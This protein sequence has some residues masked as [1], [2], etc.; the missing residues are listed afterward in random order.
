MESDTGDS[1]DSTNSG[2]SDIHELHSQLQDS[3]SHSDSSC[4]LELPVFKTADIKHNGGLFQ[5]VLINEHMLL[6]QY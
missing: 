4:D 3:S 1:S 6:I 5:C 2:Y